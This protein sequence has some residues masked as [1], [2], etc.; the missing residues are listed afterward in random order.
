MKSILESMDKYFKKLLESIGDN[1]LMI[2]NVK[3]AKNLILVSQSNDDGWSEWHPM[4]KDAM[5]SFNEL[6]EKLGITFHN[7]ICDYYN[8]Y[9]FYE[10]YGYIYIYIWGIS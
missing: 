6:E 9:W 2:S 5:T 1:K 10:I 8:S 7:D 4:K 3:N